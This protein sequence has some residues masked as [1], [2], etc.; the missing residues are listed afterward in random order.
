MAARKGDTPPGVGPEGVSGVH[1]Y[2]TAPYYFDFTGFRFVSM[3][4][5]VICQ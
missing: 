5:L 3:S 2:V 4:M 1:R